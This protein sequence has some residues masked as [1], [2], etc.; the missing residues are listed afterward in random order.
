MRRQTLYDEIGGKPAVTAVVG[1]FYDRLLA[2]PNLKRFFAGQD[3]EKL[4]SH[5][6]ALVTVALGGTDDLYTGRMMGPAH[7]GLGID[8]DS[9]DRVLAHLSD[10]LAAAQVV[11]ITIEKILAILEALRG[12]VVQSPAPAAR[13]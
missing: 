8:N 9:F 1:D 3:M 7:A 4:K 12:D 2:D 6:R 5:Q 10:A 11:P 13:L